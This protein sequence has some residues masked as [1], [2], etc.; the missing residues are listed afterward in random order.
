[1]YPYRVFVSYSH[2]N[3]DKAEAIVEHLKSIG[4]EPVW[5]AGLQWGP[6]F[7]EQIRDGIAFAHA[8]IPV[9]TA[10][11]TRRT[12]VHQEIGYALG[13]H[14][15]VLP[16][17]LGEL[18]EGMISDLQARQVGSNLQRMEELLTAEA[19]HRL[20]TQAREQAPASFEL[21]EL[22]QHRTEMLIRYATKVLNL[23]QHG[24]VRQAAAFS[25][26]CIP[27]KPTVHPI[28]DEREGQ[29]HPPESYRRLLL[30]E[31]RAL[32][33][34]AREAGCSLILS[35]FIRRDSMPGHARR[36]RLVTLL[37]FLERM[38]PEKLTVAFVDQPRGNLLI[39]GDWFEA[40]CRSPHVGRGYE[41]TVCTRHAPTVLEQIERFDERLEV[42]LEEQRAEPLRSRDKAIEAVRAG[43]EAI[44][45]TD[46]PPSD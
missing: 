6:S 2:E 28:W 40:E 23:G 17:A 18:P 4:L 38:P 21:A 34:H 26:F 45:A 22:A 1:M 25:S 32:E 14:I 33:A 46:A 9:L 44:P 36:A 20:V 30:K 29:V 11:S 13:M 8:F 5:D 42:A 10:A 31:R 7:A 41:M 43:I 16:L 19:V 15:P 3:G 12:W 39:V 37:E 35:P 24:H 27:D